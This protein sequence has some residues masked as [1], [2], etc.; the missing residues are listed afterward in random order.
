MG[1]RD[2][3]IKL[4]EVTKGDATHLEVKLSYN[5]GGMNYFT[6]NVEQR[7]IQLIVTPIKI[8]KGDGYTSRSFTAFTGIK[9]NVLEMKRF[10]QKTF[11]NFEPTQ[12]KID[13]LINYVKAKNNIETK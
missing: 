7:G 13:E 6:G 9:T 5:E 10:N 11:D 12:Q 2:R 1:K 4:L 3:E 8:S